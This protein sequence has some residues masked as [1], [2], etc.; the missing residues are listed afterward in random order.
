[1]H[2]GFDV[3]A[4]IESEGPYLFCVIS[5]GKDSHNA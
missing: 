3:N 1:M 5:E 4:A 2:L